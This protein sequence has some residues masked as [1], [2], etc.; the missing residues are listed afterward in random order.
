VPARRVAVVG[1]GLAGLVAARELAASCEVEL[2]EADARLGGKLQTVTFRGRPLDV[3]PDAFIT[4]NPAAIGLAT[5]LGLAGE[6]IEPASRSAGIFARG[7]LHPLPAG[8]AIGIPTDIAALYRSGVLSTR[9][10]LR[11][12]TDLLRRAAVTRAPGA[13]RGGGA[14]LSVAELLGPRLGRGVLET[15]VDPLI[16]GINASDVGSLSFAAALPQLLPRLEGARSVMRALRPMAA[17]AGTSPSPAVFAGLERGLG[18][19]SEALVADGAARGVRFRTDAAVHGLSPLGGRDGWHLE[20]SAGEGEFEGVVLALPAPRAATLLAG[21][22]PEL[23]AGLSDIPYASVLTATFAFAAGAVPE[24][25]SARLGAIGGGPLPGSGVLVPRRTG[26]LITAASFTSTKWPRSAATGEV[27]I[28]A[29]AGRHHDRRAVELDD[30]GVLATL[31]SDLAAVLGITEFPLE[32]VLCRFPD[33]FPQYVQGHLAR[34]AELRRLS[35]MAAPLVLTGAAY[36]GIGIPACIE[37][38]I[39]QAGLLRDA[40][41]P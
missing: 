24:A 22:S 20:S 28:R 7:T 13:A 32:H 35:K 5:D 11:C 34:V 40:L 38:A 30:A 10:V 25:V 39:A 36:D 37:G 29:S 21:Y 18:E 6:L 19:L 15:L 9:E 8:L 3:G 26:H 31:R 12:A 33:S 41:T 16:G 23:A 17:Q 14:D 27:V 4:R 2:F 1:G